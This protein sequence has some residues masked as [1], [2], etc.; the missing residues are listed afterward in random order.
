M[1]RLFLMVMAA[2]LLSLPLLAQ[3]KIVAHRGFWRTAGSAQNSLTSLQKAAE[4]GLYGSEFDVWL[5]ADGVPVVFHDAVWDG[6]RIE[7]TKYTDL[8]NKRLPNGEFLPT[9]QQYL[10]LFVKT[11]YIRPI[12]EIKTHKNDE[13][14][15]AVTEIGVKLVRELGLEDR[16]DYIAFSK[17]VCE[18]LHE[19]TP[20]SHIAYLNG[21]LSPQQIKEMG[22]SGIDYH[23][24]VF[25]KHPNW[26]KQARA[27]G[28][29]VNVWTV[30]GE[31]ELTKFANM[32]GIDLITTNDP[33]KLKEIL[34]K[35]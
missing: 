14:N 24:N 5:T 31:E 17:Y 7:D 30:D 34:K 4:L 35:K 33:D 26:A 21:D 2:S 12:F 25:D 19:I 13:R 1:K 8:M 11:P 6:L 22:I 32:P 27:L 9:L 29:E 20:Q 10:Q 15:R 16:T 23:K 18:V 3:P 28:I